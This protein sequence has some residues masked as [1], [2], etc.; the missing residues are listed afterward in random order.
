MTDPVTSIRAVYATPRDG[1]AD[2]WHD[3]RGDLTWTTLFSGSLTPTNG[4]VTGIAVVEP[5]GFLALHRHA[6]A[7]IYYLLEGTARL[8]IDGETRDVG[9]GT[10]VFIPG[11]AEHGMQNDGPVAVRCLYVLAAD[12]FEDVTYVFSDPEA[13]AEHSR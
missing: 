13:R 9:P 11:N 5:G 8:T 3:S 2:G 6:P 10:A 1:P 12:R 4:L 7:E